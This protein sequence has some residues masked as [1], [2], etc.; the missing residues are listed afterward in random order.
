MNELTKDGLSNIEDEAGLLGSH[1]P[2]TAETTS[3][4]PAKSILGSEKVR[5]FM[6]MYQFDTSEACIYGVEEAIMLHNLRF[7]IAKNKANNKHLYD[8]T[9]WTYNSVEAFSKLFPFW[10]EKQIRR[11]LS[12]L[13]SSGA[14]ASGNFNKVA[15][16]RTKWYTVMEESISSKLKIHLPKRENGKDQTGEPIPDSKPDNKPNKEPP[17]PGGGGWAPPPGKM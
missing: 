4:L 1:E 15:Y 12:S 2:R 9:Y 6:A 8:G 17:S 3:R 14:I 16:D 5:S 13:E 7:W 11:V 10:S